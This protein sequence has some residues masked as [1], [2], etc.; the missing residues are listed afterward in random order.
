[1]KTENL[2][3]TDHL[4]E[5]MATRNVTWA[6]IM[7]VVENPEVLYGP[8]HKNRY[9]AQRGNL[10]VVVSGS[11]G[12]VITVLLKSSGYWTDEEAKNRDV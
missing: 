11:N 1:M 12:A 6:E 4:R 3:P 9:V 2:H 7:S 8:D 10:S 5:K